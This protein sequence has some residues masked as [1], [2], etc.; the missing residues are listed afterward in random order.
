MDAFEAA[1]AILP[2]LEVKNASA[3]KSDAFKT[4]NDL[5]GF[6]NNKLKVED[7]EAG[8]EEQLFNKIK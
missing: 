2:Q 1:S 4:T 8:S 3:T 5:P 6:S 7:I